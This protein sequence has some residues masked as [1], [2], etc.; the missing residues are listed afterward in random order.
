MV[1]RSHVT[2]SWP[3]LARSASSALS[4][5]CGSSETGQRHSLADDCHQLQE[6]KFKAGAG[7]TGGNQVSSQVMPTK[8]GSFSNG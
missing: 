5:S 8:N 7:V 2:V 6:V 3:S 4:T 1:L